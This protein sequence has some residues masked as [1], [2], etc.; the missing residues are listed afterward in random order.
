MLHRR[1]RY[2]CCYVQL[3]LLLSRA[4]ELYYFSGFDVAYSS[5]YFHQWHCIGVGGCGL[6][7]VEGLVLDFESLE[8]DDGTL[9]EFQ[10]EGWYNFSRETR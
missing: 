6:W 10:V 4:V 7:F 9:T 5:F 2:L 8:T 3:P 1:H